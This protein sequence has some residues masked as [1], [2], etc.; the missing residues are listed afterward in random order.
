MVAILASHG[1]LRAVFLGHSY[2]TSWLSYLCKYARSAV[3]GILFLDPIC[4]CLHVPYLTKQFVYVRPDPGTVSYMV[5]TD[6]VVNWTIQR[7]FPWAHVSLFVEQLHVPTVIFLS[8][9]DALVPAT[10]VENYLRKRNIPV[11]DF[12]D[13]TADYFDQNESS[14]VCAVFRGDGHGG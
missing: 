9:K 3:S 10:K 7:S 6:V 12:T 2:G 8:D 13:C 5:R 1:F 11:Q 4:F 14:V